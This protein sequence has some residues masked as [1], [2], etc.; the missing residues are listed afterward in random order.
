MPDGSHGGAAL[1]FAEM[2]RDLERSQP[3]D[4][5]SALRELTKNA[6]ASL[7]G[8]VCA[9]ITVATRAGEVRSMA[10]SD[11]MAEELDDIQRRTREGPCLTSAWE[12]H[13]IRISDMATETRWPAFCREALRTTDARSAQSFQ[14]FKDRESM[15]ALNF[16]G[17]E[18]DAF[19]EESLELG[20]ILATHTAVAWNLLLRDDQ[21]RS[22]LTSR[23][24]IGQAKGMLMER[25]SIDAAAAFGLLRRL[26]QET[27]NPLI[28]VAEQVIQTSNK[29]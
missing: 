25:Y 14:L 9:G 2:L 23:D 19:D 17:D 28:S 3:S 4:T 11:A 26:S 29:P 10:A 6:A 12:Q 27:N 16:Y 7:P 24:V 15:G 13:T 20:L 1:R 8:A 18:V 5:E 22:A 21:F